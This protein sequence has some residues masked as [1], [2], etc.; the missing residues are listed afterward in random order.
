MVWELRTLDALAED[1]NFGSH[2]P[3]AVYKDL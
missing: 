2:P 3:T 1:L